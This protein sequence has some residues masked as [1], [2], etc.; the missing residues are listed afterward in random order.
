MQDHTVHDE[1]WIF[2][3]K[4]YD[5]FFVYFHNSFTQWMSKL[6]VHMKYFF[7]DVCA[8]T[9]KPIGKGS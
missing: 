9:S 5:F 3:L 4:F 1:M 8:I 6:F 7:L 2:V